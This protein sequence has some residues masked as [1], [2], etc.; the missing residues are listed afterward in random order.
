[1]RTVRW[2][3]VVL[4]LA[5]GIVAQTAHAASPPPSLP[6]PACSVVDGVKTGACPAQDDAVDG[7]ASGSFGEGSTVLVTTAPSIGI[8]IASYGGTWDPSPCF[9]AIH[10]PSVGT[11]GYIDVFDGNTFKEGNCRDVLY[12][13]TAGVP[14]SLFSLAGAN[15]GACQG[16]GNFG[17]YIYG[18]PA[19]VAGARWSEFGPA[20]LDCNV[21]FNGP[22]PDGMY[23]PTWVK[24]GVG[25]TREQNPYDSTTRVR[26]AEFYVPVDGDMREQYVDLELSMSNQLSGGA[27]DP[28]DRIYA[29]VSNNGGKD[30][31]AHFSVPLPA[32]M[33]VQ[34]ATVDGGS[35]TLPDTFTGGEV[36]CD[37]TVYGKGDQLGRDTRSIQ[38]IARIV[39]AS[40]FVDDPNATRL[41]GTVTADG[42]TDT[43]NNSE[44]TNVL[45][46]LLDGSVD[47]TR[48][49]MEALAPYF[50]YKAPP[51]P[52]G[53]NC[54]RY[55]DNIFERLDAIRQQFPA[56]LADLAFGKI[57][58]SDGGSGGRAGRDGVVVYRKGTNYHQTGIV[59]YGTPARSAA[60]S[61]E[62]TQRGTEAPGAH[63]SLTDFTQGTADHFWYY[64]TAASIFA[65]G[66]Q[67]A[68]PMG[69]GLEGVYTDN[70]NQFTNNVP[71]S[72]VSAAAPS[73]PFFP[74]AVVVQTQSPV[75]II[76]TNSR[77]RIVQT[78]GGTIGLQE[79]QT[80]IWSFP[81]QHTDGTFAWT[82]VL[83]PDD[84]D[85]KLQGTGTGPY[86][87]TLT[88]FDDNG[89]AVNQEYEGDTTPGQI[90]DYSIAA[91]PV[92]GGG[93][94]TG[95]GGA[96]ASGGGGG[97]AFGLLGLLALGSL[98]GWRMR[99]ARQH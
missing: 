19:N 58:S 87:L 28:T 65:S 39:D 96:G 47:D 32:Q 89:N 54:D 2:L 82:L 7:H 71:D 17:V 55:T 42:D 80:G 95:S 76:A 73:C 22:R 81:V 9:S 24:V 45:L 93:S 3:G 29:D 98:V 69:C 79:L 53:T 46:T 61:D 15:G 18:G 72:C 4:L 97:G 27:E 92:T 63:V 16:S 90:N 74:T 20:L 13:S 11:C 99:A 77:G 91:A 40:N 51:D 88:K 94:G 64:R 84:Y 85:V 59:V 52:F 68:A 23:G 83:P 21:T 26:Y 34:S 36:A 38:V 70:R 49:L 44:F 43:S 8:C 33:H 10:T 60:D 41:V 37:V 6:L 25:V 66:S 30:A 35:C 56:A 86:K 5:T 57:L 78:N 50:D 1:M 31:A 14:S 67:S 48:L 12:K 75:D 62:S